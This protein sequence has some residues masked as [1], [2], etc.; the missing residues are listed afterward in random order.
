MN[1]TNM[2]EES[3]L[4]LQHYKRNQVIT[5][6]WLAI[7][8]FAIIKLII[9]C[10]DDLHPSHI[11]ELNAVFDLYL[12]GFT[13]TFALG[14]FEKYFSEGSMYCIIINF[15]DRTLLLSTSGSLILCQIDRFLFL[16][17]NMAYSEVI[18]IRKAALACVGQK[19]LMALLT[20][21]GVFVDPEELKCSTF[22]DMKKV[23]ACSFVR[24]ANFFWATIPRSVMLLV[25]LVV[26]FYVIHLVIKQN[27]TVAPVI[28]IAI[29]PQ[30]P[31]NQESNANEENVRR[32][33]SNPSLFYRVPIP[34]IPQVSNIGNLL[35]QS[36]TIEHH[37]DNAKRLLS[38]NIQTFAVLFLFVPSNILITYLFITGESCETLPKIVPFIKTSV[39]VQV[40]VVLPIYILIVW[41]R[42]QKISSL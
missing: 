29:I 3:E 5:S 32:L 25:I 34:K 15:L 12:S 1:L 41:K 26:T 19:L 38:V 20:I 16:Y 36:S 11:F 4:N 23:Q 8:F 24:S 39:I 37:M 9:K 27:Q 17:L 33:N 10:K 30:P 7:F 35:P 28:P 6:I 14:T 21:L 42:F 13:G 2:T 31:P 22:E 18:S 40:I